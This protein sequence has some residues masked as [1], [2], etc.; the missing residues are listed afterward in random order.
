MNNRMSWLTVGWWTALTALGVF[1]AGGLHF[2]GDFGTR[3]WG[4][5]VPNWGSGVVG[6]VFGS[7]SGLFIAGLP[8]LLLPG[9]GVWARRW[10]GYNLLAYGLIHAMA[11]AL[12][13]RPL[14]IWAGGPILALCQCLALRLKLSQ[15]IVWL[16]IVTV[17]WWL[18]FG[19]TVGATGYNL[20]VIGPLLGV[21]TGL[22]LKWLLIPAS[23]IPNRWWAAQRRPMRFLV[24][25]VLIIGVAGF[26][27][28]FAG[29]SGLMGMFR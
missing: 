27:V 19:L 1:L 14:V 18:G 7:V 17:T 26:L 10:I 12:P 23:A 4:L 5:V 21:I 25:I 15:P 8:A 16:P 3:F 20:V 2:P 22:M 29:L 24:V 28:L 9:L 11:D 13:Y 6:F